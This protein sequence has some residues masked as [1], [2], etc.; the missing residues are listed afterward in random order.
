MP[1]RTLPVIDVFA[2][3][4]GLGEGFTQYRNAK[5]EHAFH[6]SLSIEKDPIAH[7]T[8][9]LRAFVRQFR[10]FR[11][12]DEY[13]RFIRGDISEDALFSA[14]PKQVAAAKLEA[15]NAELGGTSIADV[16]DRIR[17]TIPKRGNWILIG[18]PP[19]QAYSLVGRSRNKGIITY[20]PEHDA[21]QTLY[22]EYLQIIADHEPA[23][24]VMENVKGLLSAKLESQHLFERI[25]DDLRDPAKALRREHRTTL[26]KNGAL[27]DVYPL[28]QAD[29]LFSLN[30]ADYVLRA[31]RYGIPQARHRVVLLGVRSDLRGKKPGRLKERTIT[32]CGDV[33][34]GL[35]RVRSGVHTGG[36]SKDEWLTVVASAR[37]TAWLD[38]VRSNGGR[39]V[40]SKILNV[41]DGLTAPQKGRG[42]EFVP[43]DVEA[44][45]RKDWFLD[46]RIGGACNHMTRRHMATDLHRYLFASAYAKVHGRSPQLVDFPTRLLPK[47]RNV[48]RA[49]GGGYFADRFRVQVAGKCATT[50]TSHLSKDGHYYIHPDP[51]QCRSLTV[52]EAARIQTFPDNYFFRGGRTAQYVQ[53]GNA[54]PPLLAKQIARV[55]S[56]LLE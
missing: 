47:H 39:D 21:R 50:V 2:G 43:Y 19:C 14:F 33:L 17:S 24:F 54:V 16:R 37:D 26:N 31:E 45:Y 44:I 28:A 48:E 56:E 30:P 32:A 10:D 11:I 25:L 6:I 8:L 52:R 15:W 20:A 51:S 35:P 1:S 5:G 49:L 46:G 34:A 3:P 36:D 4:G 13:Y 42:G 29:S 18:G 53:V 38:S 40:A 9:Q 55:V 23:V 12:P 41:L 27:Y 22:V 7:Q